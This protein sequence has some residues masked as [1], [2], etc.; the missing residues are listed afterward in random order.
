MAN[1]AA[2][3]AAKTAVLEPLLKEYYNPR[4]GA[5]DMADAIPNGCKM[6]IQ[7][8][9]VWV[10]CW[11]HV[12]RAVHKT[13][14]KKLHDS[15]EARVDMLFMNMTFLHGVQRDRAVAARGAPLQ[16]LTLT[17]PSRLLTRDLYL[18][19]PT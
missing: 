1:K 18:R 8:I 2:K 5:S 9:K 16:G 14:L 10:A 13:G 7:S 4:A 17:N 19:S 15:G 11:A 12:W 3:K 6:A